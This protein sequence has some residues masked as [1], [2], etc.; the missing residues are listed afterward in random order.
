[1][2]CAPV[3]IRHHIKILF[4]R[5]VLTFVMKTNSFFIGEC[6]SSEIHK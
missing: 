1:M 6:P 5:E 3:Y 2:G 4:P